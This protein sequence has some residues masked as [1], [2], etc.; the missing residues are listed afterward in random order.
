MFDRGEVPR[1]RP[2][3]AA[4]RLDRAQGAVT[5]A[6]RALLGAILACEEAGLWERD[7]FRSLAH[8][9][10][11]R[12]GIS[13]WAARRMVTAA[14]ALEA[15]P[16]TARA[17][18]RGTLCLEKVVELCRFA[19]KETEAELIAWARTVRPATIRYRADAA[20]RAELESYRDAHRSR[21]LQWWWSEDH[22]RLGLC[23]EFPSDQG[24][25]LIKALDRAASRLPDVVTGEDAPEIPGAS[26][27]ERRAD[28]LVALASARLAADQDP[29][30]A[31][32]VV[33]AE[34]SALVGNERQA[35]L[36]GGGLI[37]P[38]TA[39]RLACDCRLEIL[40][41][42]NRRPVGVGRES[43]V[44][45]RW[46]RRQLLYRDRGCL[47]PGCG[48]R[49]FLHCH[50]IVHWIFGGRT[51]LDNLALV[52]SYHHRLVHEFG[53]DIELGPPGRAIW[54]RPDGSRYR[55]GPGPPSGA[56]PPRRRRAA[57]DPAMPR[58]SAAGLGAR[59]IP[60]GK[61]IGD[62]EERGG[63]TDEQTGNGGT[64][65]RLPRVVGA[66]RL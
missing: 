46:L 39:R 54:Y 13:E 25:V 9:L 47:F 41:G 5:S 6:Q 45:P 7:G 23:G 62:G 31:T 21:Y 48:A 30:R 40:A 60:L 42:D 17:L 4:A 2:E 57:S 15:L 20:Q 18:E 3:T 35:E 65:R 38:E 27:E 55:L 37:H 22:T 26:L 44:P 52:C 56:G 29:D 11:G 34:L 36:E 33:H 19:T 28:A 10:A 1:P 32:V 59:H 58:A 61:W 8:W 49:R 16:E 64:G 24:G 63:R 43:R 50:H 53:W 51:D 12:L 14:H 66:G